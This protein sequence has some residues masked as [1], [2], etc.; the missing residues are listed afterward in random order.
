MI[1]CNHFE[2]HKEMSVQIYIRKKRHFF[3][4]IAF[5]VQRF[6]FNKG[7]PELCCNKEEFAKATLLYKN[8]L[9]ESGYKTSMSYAQTEVKT[10]KNGSQNIISP[11]PTLSQNVKTNIGKFFLKLIKKKFP[12]HHRLH[13]I[14]NLNTIRLS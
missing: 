14:S 10:N 4:N 6:L 12:I 11:N 5:F 7:L 1:I 13:K 9:Q 8:S 3:H 2:C